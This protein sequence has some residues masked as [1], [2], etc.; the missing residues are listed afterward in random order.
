MFRQPGGTWMC[1]EYCEALQSPGPSGNATDL[2]EECV[3]PAKYNKQVEV[4]SVENSTESQTHKARP[5]INISHL[6]Q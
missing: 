4:T 1:M 6:R 3:M 5:S 2:W